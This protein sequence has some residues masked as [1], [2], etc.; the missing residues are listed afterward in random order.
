MSVVCARSY[1]ASNGFAGEFLRFC[2]DLLASLDHIVFI[3]VLLL[4]FLPIH[5]LPS[6]TSKRA[7]RLQHIAW[8]T[9]PGD[10]SLG[11]IF[12]RKDH[13]AVAGSSVL[14]AISMCMTSR[15]MVAFAVSCVFVIPSA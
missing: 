8:T 3:R 14:A 6:W 9:H 2:N 1:K 7:S 13:G 11:N 5:R 4:P 15:N 12:S 10:K